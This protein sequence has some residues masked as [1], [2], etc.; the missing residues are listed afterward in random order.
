VPQL[1]GVDDGAD[2]GDLSAGDLER[3][4]AQQ[5]LPS[6]EQQRP[7][8]AVDLDGPQRHA[9]NAGDPGPVVDERTRDLDAPAQRPRE[10]RNLAAAVG[11]Q[12]HVVREQRLEPGEVAVLGGREE[13]SC[14]LVA[15]LARGLEAGPTL[16]EVASGAGG[17]LAHVVSLLPTIAVISG[18]P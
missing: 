2:A 9:R 17:E 12:L 13:P 5:P 7:R 8:A 15:L 4:H 10:R 18:Y 6:V 14:Q 1:V 16:L 11:G 3:Q